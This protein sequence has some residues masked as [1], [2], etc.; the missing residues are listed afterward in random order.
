MPPHHTHT[1][2][3]KFEPELLT[4]MAVGALERVTR[5]PAASYRTAGLEELSRL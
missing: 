1:H 4:L 2:K 5:V 3:I